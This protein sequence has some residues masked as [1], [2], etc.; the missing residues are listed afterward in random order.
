MEQTKFT[1]EELKEIEK[2]FDNQASLL[3]QSFANLFNSIARISSVKNN[4]EK[5]LIRLLN[6]YSKSFDV[7]RTIS[8]KANVMQNGK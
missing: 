1:R 7:C 8:A 2:I 3:S 6:E 5:L 4:S